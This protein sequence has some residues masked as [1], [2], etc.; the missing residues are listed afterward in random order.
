M[1]SPYYA[2]ESLC[3]SGRRS[4]RVWALVLLFAKHMHVAPGQPRLREDL[5][6]RAREAN[7]NG[8]Y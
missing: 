7:Q 1:L 2:F 4:A 6:P 3:I 8:G 5:V